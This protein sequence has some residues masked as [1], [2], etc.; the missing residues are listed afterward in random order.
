MSTISYMKNFIKDRNIASV[1]PTSKQ[2]V[3]E[4]A[5][6]MDFTK[7]MTIVE[8]GPATGVFTE[9]LLERMTDDSLII[10]IEM[11]ENFVHELQGNVNDSRL[12]VCHDS[13]ENVDTIVEQYA[14]SADYA[15]SGIPF[16]LMDDSM[17][18]RI[19]QK[20]SQVLK[21]GGRFFPYQTFFQKDAHL[22]DH[23]KQHFPAVKDEYFFRNLPPMRLYEAAK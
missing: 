5:N 2:G 4:I 9:H 6:R 1:T 20:T 13:A 15:L 22:L 3:R 11:N 8:Y 19:V 23:L 10:A 16:S 17:R 21:E 7:P 18:S 14:S 12:I